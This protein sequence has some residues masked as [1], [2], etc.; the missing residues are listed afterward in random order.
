MRLQL[1][2]RKTR[3]GDHMLRVPRHMQRLKLSTDRGRRLPLPSFGLSWIQ[4]KL[5]G[6][7]VV[8]FALTVCLLIL[9]CGKVEPPGGVKLPP[10]PLRSMKN[11][12]RKGDWQ[13]ASGYCDAVLE[14]H[15]DEPDTIALVAQVAHSSGDVSRAADLLVRACEAES[16]SNSARIQ[17]A[18]VALVG[19][20]KLYDGIDM[21]EEAIAKQPV[22]FE[23]TPG[24]Q[25]AHV[26]R[27][28]PGPLQDVIRQ[29]K[30]EFG[31]AQPLGLGDEIGFVLK[32]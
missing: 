28:H 9:G 32:R 14:K 8:V 1:A 31:P 16:F 27:T 3:A 12:I 22:T 26:E 13:T 21:L 15:G 2:E 29:V 11:A 19:V 10:R 7:S 30:P 17:Q 25:G 18:M 4:A 23:H 24:E 5:A 20:G 6:Y